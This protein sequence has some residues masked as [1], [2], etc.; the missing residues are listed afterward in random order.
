MPV[1]LVIA[2]LMFL[3][4]RTTT[5]ADA[6]RFVGLTVGF[7]AVLGLFHLYSGDGTKELLKVAHDG[8]GGGYIGFG[9]A[10]VLENFTG[11][12]AGTIILKI[13]RAH[14]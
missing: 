5:L 14:V 8:Q 11:K 13:G 1:L 6:V 3:K 7:F 12:I 10:Y 9:F 4:R 2:G